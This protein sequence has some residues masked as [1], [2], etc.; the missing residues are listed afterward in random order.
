MPWPGTNIPAPWD[1]APAA[2][3]PAPPDTTQRD[4]LIKQLGEQ[5]GGQVGTP[6]TPLVK[7][8]NPN[9]KQNE[10]TEIP[11]PYD[12][13]TFA[14]GTSV[15]IAPTGEVS[16]YTVKAPSGT[17]TGWTDITQVRNADQ[18]I[19]FYGK[20]PK[21]PGGP[22]KPVEGLPVSA[23]PTSTTA[24]P[25]PT[26][27]LDQ[28]KDPKTGQVIGW[29]D[30]STGSV[31]DIPKDPAGSITAVGDK[32]YVIKPDGSS[33]PA[34]DSVTGQPLTKSKDPITANV[35]GVGFVK[36]DPNTNE[37]T[38]LVSSPKGVQANSL[39]P[40]V[41][42]G[43][44]Y[45]P[46]DGPNGDIVWKETDLPADVTYTMAANDPRSKYITLLDNQGQAKYVEK[47]PDWK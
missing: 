41:R 17:T 34:V 23:A 18:T 44:T 10:P 14:D 12:L 5:H 39:K 36:Y 35:S 7:N 26:D 45:V 25:T 19:S 43:K 20:D 31:I 16:K 37:T 33:T 24:K 3:P 2:P 6:S 30:P 27:Q 1:P 21:D 47:A 38:V 8:P 42:N 29:R 46:Y 40:E 22:L 11:G 32:L 15:E 4:A 13:Y 9:P 28:V